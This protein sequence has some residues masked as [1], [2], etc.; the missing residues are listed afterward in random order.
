[1]S[2]TLLT[3]DHRQA[4]LAAI[5][6]KSIE[7]I[8]TQI[9]A[10]IRLKREL[11]LPPALSEQEVRDAYARATVFAMPSSKEGFG[12]V[13]LEALASGLPVVATVSAAIPEVVPQCR[14]GLLVPPRDVEALAGALAQ[15]LL[16]PA[17]RAEM[18][19]FGWDHVQQF[20]W[21]RVALRFLE[22]VKRWM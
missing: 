3:P 15:L 20:A 4:M 14:A 13:Y 11:N 2:Y 9:P 6:A 17:R 21:P 12:I 8:L 10:E 19:T 5:G 18:A 1:M 16:D 7:E 22:Q